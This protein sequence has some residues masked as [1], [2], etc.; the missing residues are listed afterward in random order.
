MVATTACAARMERGCISAFRL[1]RWL[2]IYF[3]SSASPVSIQITVHCF[4]HKANLMIQVLAFR[5]RPR[6]VSFVPLRVGFQ[7]P[8]LVPIAVELKVISND[9]ML[10]VQMSFRWTSEEIGP[11]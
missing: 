5:W 10:S 6:G 3:L 8:V 9:S 11:K 2:N 1:S 4:R 7:L